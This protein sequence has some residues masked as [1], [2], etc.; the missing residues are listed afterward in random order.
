MPQVLDLEALINPDNLAS[1]IGNQWMEW[2]SYRSKW[3]EQTRELRNYLYATD[4]KT[5]G[6]ALLP[7][8]NTTTTPK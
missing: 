8:S 5:T 7:W 4:T 1:E 3:K 6:N 2:D